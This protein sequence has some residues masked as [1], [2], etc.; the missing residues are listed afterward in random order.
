[1]TNK[2]LIVLLLNTDLNAQV[3][4]KR[5]IG[6]VVFKPEITGRWL[7][8]GQHAVS[9]SNCACRVSLKASKDMNY[10]F[11]CGAIMEKLHETED[12]KID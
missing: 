9:C 2:E 6:D 11:K 4:L 10:C 1:M 5:T 12:T 8:E 7:R 3:D